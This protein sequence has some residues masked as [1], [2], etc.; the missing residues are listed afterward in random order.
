MSGR[1]IKFAALATALAT[2]NTYGS[3][4]AAALFLNRAG[5][6]AIPLYY[7]LYAVLSIPVAIVFSQ[8]IDRHPR[9]A[10]FTALMV[11]GA[12]LTAAVAPAAHTE[13]KT[14]LYTLYIVIS[15]FEQLSYSVFYVLMADYFTSVETNHSTTAIAVGMA[16]GGL[17]GGVL[18]G[19]GAGT[20]HAA[21]LLLGMPALLL[22]TAFIFGLM[23]RRMV[24]LGEAEPQAEEGL[25]ASLAAFPPLIKRYPIAGLLAL[26]VFLNIVVQS[27]TEYQVFVIYTER[28]ADEAALTR[29][30]GVLNG[31]L[32]LVN[33][34]TSFA[35]TGPLLARLGVARMNLVYPAMTVSAFAALGAWFAL[36][37]A[38]FAH[39]VYDPWAHSVDA[40]TF[41]ANYNAL[42]HRFVGRVRIFCDGLAYPAAMAAA[43]GALWFIQTR[44]S[45]GTVT[46]AGLVMA[47]AFL[48]CGLAIRRAYAHGLMDMLRSG[49]VELDADGVREIPAS[50]YTDIR[51][52][53]QSN[54]ASDQSFGLEIAARADLRIFQRDIQELLGRA[55]G[56]VRAAFIRAC[57]GRIGG[58]LTAAMTDMLSA[59]EASVRA[60]ATE[61][62]VGAKH[63]FPEADLK[64]LLKDAASE[65]RG[66]AAI[67]AY[68]EGVDWPAVAPA[69]DA[70]FLGSEPSRIRAVGAVGQRGDPRLVPLLARA[71]T[72]ASLNT[73]GA[74]LDAA[75]RLAPSRET[76]AWAEEA[77]MCRTNDAG[78]L[79]AGAYRLLARR[80]DLSALP[81]LS[82]GLRDPLKEVRSA[83]AIALARFGQEALPVLCEALDSDNDLSQGAAIEAAGLIG[84]PAV[85]DML[86]THLARR[87]F[88]T[89]RRN[90]R[91]LEM[92]PPPSG[93]GDRWAP[94]A[95]ALHDS[96]QR[97]VE[98]ALA[99]L[100]ALGHRRTLQAMRGILAGGDARS[101]ANAVETI[102]SVGQ[103]R[104]VQPLLPI[105]ELGVDAAATR[106]GK[107]TED[108]L[109]VMLAE[110]ADDPNR[111][112]CA[113]ALLAAPLE[114]RRILTFGY[115][116]SDDPIVRDAA[117]FSDDPIPA[118]E[119]IMNRLMF[120]RTV[121]L[122]EGLSLDDLLSV[123][124]ALE[125]EEYLANEIV[126]RQGEPGATLF[127]VRRGS[128][129]VLLENR[130]GS[131]PREVAQL[132]EGEYFGEMSLFEDLPRSATVITLTDAVF[133]SLD[134][135]RFSTLA[136]QRPVVLMRICRMFGSRL[137]ETDRRLLAV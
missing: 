95:D 87:Y 45:Q 40:P 50:R 84:G 137:R 101:R 81:L 104:F 76:A 4:L 48:A 21:D 85:D 116:R 82:E 16:L 103:R 52:L 119:T 100:A 57:S 124:E 61:V 136:M 115:D 113:G 20:F 97:A 54:D 132:R 12:I 29:F 86:Y 74:V 129:S 33:I 134:R 71:R 15:V 42:P 46:A 99:V 58:T 107:G 120:L 63:A 110:A 36:P 105:L 19:V 80:G 23:R 130:D 1:V 126:V 112:I 27:I 79:R 49:S 13:S 47:L 83:A 93:P 34:V 37:A 65:V 106:R 39:V 28:F 22:I 62:L 25:L 88:A 14:L 121:P 59:E 56:P 44:V 5:S 122:F 8:I 32:N 17:I 41:V 68:S 11:G 125:R 9:N 127:I 69:L 118:Q 70:I 92:L 123:D 18:A 96:N 30:L 135:D 66:L 73:R 94:L 26:G 75:A 38:I 128:V 55:S 7:V 117:N 72:D 35:L 64:A 114:Q 133:L 53:L 91:W 6:N 89:V 77:L 108:Q 43:G 102:A 109:A 67:H 10:L 111:W 78:P 98:T 60:A 24:A 3:T 131:A 51:R 31:A 2:A 90:S